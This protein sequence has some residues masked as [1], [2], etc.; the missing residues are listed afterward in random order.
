MKN[1][2]REKDEKE[3]Q[4]EREKGK[5]K[6]VLCRCNYRRGDAQSTSIGMI[7]VVYSG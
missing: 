1:V 3:E 7:T 2:R 6:A 5:K 4:K